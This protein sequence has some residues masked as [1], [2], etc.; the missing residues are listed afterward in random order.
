MQTC[1]LPSLFGLQFFHSKLFPG[2]THTVRSL[3]TW[4]NL[5]FKANILT[6]QRKQ[7]VEAVKAR[8][9]V[10]LQGLCFPNLII[11]MNRAEYHLWFEWASLSLEFCSSCEP[12]IVILVFCLFVKSNFTVPVAQCFS[13]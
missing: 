6:G 9:K 11:I 4:I 12:F 3:L 13:G 10:V 2:C 5:Q 7:L 8:W 1:F